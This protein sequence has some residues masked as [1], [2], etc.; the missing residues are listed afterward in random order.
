MPFSEEPQTWAEEHERGEYEL[1]IPALLHADLFHDEHMDRG[2][3]MRP[4][5]QHEHGYRQDGGNGEADLEAAQF[6]FTPV[7]LAL[8]LRLP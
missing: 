4:H 5:F 1:Q 8:F 3:E 6:G 7:G 2:H